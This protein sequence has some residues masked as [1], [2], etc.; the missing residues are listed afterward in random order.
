MKKEFHLL[1]TMVLSYSNGETRKS[2]SIEKILSLFTQVKNLLDQSKNR[3]SL[4]QIPLFLS[5]LLEI[6]KIQMV[7]KELPETNGLLKVQQLTWTELMSKKEK[8]SDLE[9]SEK[10]VL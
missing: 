2:D 3:L 1:M 10:V 7:T 6:S 8:L 4:L 5:K 9:S